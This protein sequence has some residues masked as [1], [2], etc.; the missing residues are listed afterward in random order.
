LLIEITQLGYEWATTL[1]AF[2]SIL[3]VPI[4]WLWFY[5]GQT[6]RMKSPFA[7]EHFAQDEDAPH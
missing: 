6:L 3:M 5:R 4:I 1:L 7:R 2:L